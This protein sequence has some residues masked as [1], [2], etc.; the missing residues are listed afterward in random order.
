MS[1]PD[2]M[3]ASTS[4]ASD[5]SDMSDP[6][7]IFAIAQAIC[8]IGR[9]LDARGFV[10]GNEGNVSV[11]IGEDR[12]LCT[13]TLQAKGTL[14][15]EDLVV[16]DMRGEHISGTKR[17]SSEALLHLAIYTA[18]PDVRAVVHCHPPHATAFALTH[19]P[20]PR[21]ITPEVEVF[22]GDVEL[23]PYETPGTEA[24]AQSV[25]PYVDRANALILANHGTVSYA[26]QLEHAFWFT[27]ILDAYCRTVI[28]AQQLGP[29]Q[30][31]PA[32]KLAAVQ[33]AR[34]KWGFLKG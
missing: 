1:S 10:A 2:G 21:G 7:D 3:D 6:S 15:P 26:A 20:V 32:D 24:F 25:V 31:L 12:V 23:T 8:G 18:R 22:L 16:I 4:D 27:E 11:R 19:T 29:L 34:A 28:L 17:R 30:P 9:R 33:A 13:P 14:R 5:Q